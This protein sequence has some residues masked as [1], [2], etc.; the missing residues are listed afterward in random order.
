M[1][2]QGRSPVIGQILQVVCNRVLLSGLPSSSAS[3]HQLLARLSTLRPLFLRFS[4]LSASAQRALL[5]M[6]SCACSHHRRT[7]VD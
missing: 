2:L 4:A 6:S 1:Q 3:L 7:V 5:E